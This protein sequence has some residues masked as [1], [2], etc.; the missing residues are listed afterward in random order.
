MSRMSDNLTGWSLAA[1]GA[2]LAIAAVT[3]VLLLST[4]PAASATPT[5]TVTAKRTE[6]GTIL[7]GPGGEV[8]YAFSR[9]RRDHDACAAIRGCLSVW[10]ML[11]VHG[12]LRAG[13]GVDRSRLSTITVQGE[14]QVTYAGH[15]LYTFADGERP[16]D[17]DYVGESQSGG[18][19]PAVSPGGRLVR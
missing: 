9:D 14:R 10:P 4:P 1:T 18:S 5:T 13:R 7:L 3:T 16:G 8:L 17:T 19:W 12:S 2:V 15:P 11:T 6:V